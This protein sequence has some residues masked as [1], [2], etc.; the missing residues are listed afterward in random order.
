MV[1][2]SLATTLVTSSATGACWSYADC[3]GA[4][5]GLSADQAGVCFIASLV[6]QILVG[7]VVAVVG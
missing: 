6:F 7:L 2:I 4:E 3:F 1:L 5:I